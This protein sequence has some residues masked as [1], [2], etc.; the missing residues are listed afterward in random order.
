[1]KA[2]LLLSLLILAAGG[3]LGWKQHGQLVTV[4]ETHRQVAEEARALGLTPEALLEAGKPP[5]PT[6]VPTSAGRPSPSSS[7][8]A[9]PPPRPTRAGRP[10]PCQ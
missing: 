4:R 6:F 5:R 7:P 9:V 8:I 3:L 2:P 1:M 10:P